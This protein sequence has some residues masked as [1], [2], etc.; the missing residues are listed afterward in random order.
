MD[1]SDPVSNFEEVDEAYRFWVVC[2]WVSLCVHSSRTVQ[3][4]VF[5]YS[6]WKKYLMLIFS[7]VRVIPLSGVIPAL[8]KI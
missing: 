7:L 6:S 1:L 4:R 3:A 8:N 5:I 2:P